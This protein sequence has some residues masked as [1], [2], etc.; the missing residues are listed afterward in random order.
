[1]GPTTDQD[2]LE[3][4]KHYAS[5]GHTPRQIASL[6]QIPASDKELFL[7]EFTD[8]EMKVAEYF[9]IG[10][11]IGYYNQNAELTKAAEKGDVFAVDA[12]DRRKREQ[13]SADLREEL[14]HI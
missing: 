4:I 14:F 6:L 7:Y 10:Q 11:T 12:L 9:A 8:P 13:K 3:K 2:T 1:M 5:L